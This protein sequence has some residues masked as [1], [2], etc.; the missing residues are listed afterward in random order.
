MS[1]E[2]TITIEE[3]QDFLNQQKHIV[4][5]HITKNLS[6]YKWFNDNSSN[7][8]VD[9]CKVELRDAC[10]RADLPDDFLVLKKYIK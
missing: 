4:G 1:K 5:Q 8:S 6:Q 2:I 10:G 7:I 9:G 3:L